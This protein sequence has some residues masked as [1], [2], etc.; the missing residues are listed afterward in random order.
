MG[1]IWNDSVKVS[2]LCVN[3]FKLVGLQ[4]GLFLYLGMF[5]GDVLGYRWQQGFQEPFQEDPVIQLDLAHT[6]TSPPLMDV[7]GDVGRSVLAER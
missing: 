4:D 2:R 5:R 7:V 3:E 1:G 6:A